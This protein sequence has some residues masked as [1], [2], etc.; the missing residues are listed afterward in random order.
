MYRTTLDYMNYATN[1][2]SFSDMSW[3]PLLNRR[4]ACS[5]MYIRIIFLWHSGQLSKYWIVLFS[6]SGKYDKHQQQ[7]SQS[8]ICLLF[9]KSVLSWLNFLSTYMLGSVRTTYF[10]NPTKSTNVGFVSTSF[11]FHFISLIIYATIFCILN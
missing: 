8:R 11:R 5:D 4:D 7:L 9:I 2:P 6:K 3:S 1:S 10:N